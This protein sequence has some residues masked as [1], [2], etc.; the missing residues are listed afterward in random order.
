MQTLRAAGPR[1]PDFVLGRLDQQDRPAP[2]LQQLLPQAD[3]ESPFRWLSLLALPHR[4][5]P[6]TLERTAQQLRAEA[7][8]LLGE[9]TE[10]QP[11]STAYYPVD[12]DVDD[13][14][15]SLN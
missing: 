1:Q 7:D 13:W 5:D 3:P 12:L 2:E 11:T 15:A 6:A 14:L 8:L 4:P 10:P 9:D